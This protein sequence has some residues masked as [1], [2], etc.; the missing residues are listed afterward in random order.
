MR[1]VL[2]ILALTLAFAV[3]SRPAAA[4]PYPV[5]PPYQEAVL[6]NDTWPMSDCFYKSGQTSLKIYWKRVRY[7]DV[8]QY[9]NMMECSGYITKK[10]LAKL[11]SYTT[12]CWSPTNTSCV[13]N[14]DWA[15][16]P[17]CN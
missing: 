11:Y 5:G 7:Y 2:V 6:M 8:N 14:Q 3:S 16:S 1:R 4:C 9:Q 13:G 17:I 15:P 10:F 12:T